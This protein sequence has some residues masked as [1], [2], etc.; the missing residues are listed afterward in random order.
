M[1]IK[2]QGSTIIDDS[3]NIIN[4]TQVGIATTTTSQPFQV[5]SGTT[6]IV[7]D[8]LGDLGIGTPNPTSKLTVVGD[9]LVSGVVTASS[10]RGDGSQLFGVSGGV[11]ISTNTTNQNQFLTYAISTGT[12]TGLGVTTSGLV[13]NPSTTRFGI[14]ITNPQYTFTVTDTGTPATTG[15][16]NCLADFTT[17]AN[18]YGQINLRNTS[19]GTNASSDVIIT[20][21]NGTDSSNFID[22]GI[23]NSGFSVGSWTI[24]GA[25]DGYLYTS[26]GNLSIG[27]INASVAKYISFFTG[28]TLLSNERMRINSTG[29]G[30]NTTNP[31]AT[32]NV[33]PTATSIAGL[34]SGTTSSDMVRITQL[35]TGNALVVEDETNPDAGPFVVK[36]DGSVG[37][38]TTN[39]SDKLHVLGGNIRV[40]SV[41][42]AV[43]FWDGAGFYGGIGGAGGLGGSG[44]DI[45]IRADSTRSIIFFTGGANDR[46]RIDSSGTFLV[47]AATSTGTA[48]QRL[49]VDG[50]AYISG[51]LGIGT[52]NPQGTLQ[53]GAA[54]TMYGSAGIVSATKYYG[55][56]S[57]LTNIPSADSYLFNTGITSSFS[58][59]LLGIGSTIFTFPATAGKKYV[60][61]SVNCSNVSTGNTE[62]NVIGAFDFN[63]GERSYFAYNIPI[64][65]GTA[66]EI[67]KQPQVLN[68]SD[69]IVMRSTN[70]SRV[71]TD[72]IVEVYVSYQEKTTTSYFGIGISTTGFATTDVTGIYTATT[73]PSVIQ[74]IRLANVTDSGGYPV[75]VQITNGLTTTRLV[76]NLIVPKYAS[77]EILDAPKRIE[78]NSV[79]QLQLDQ[80]YTISAQVSGSQITS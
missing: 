40:D 44:T 7:V 19:T 73:Y 18:S 24:N 64:P 21:D 5:G 47:G 31:G 26:D 69:R 1:A 72:S 4:A 55:D 36:G 2:V 61:L 74:S 58:T 12:T 30:I 33:V 77:V 68:P 37:I 43:N 66:V 67:M 14:G 39:T 3:R 48:S 29:V 27:A 22:L 6:I 35:G 79:I 62:V 20:A 46:G 8:N 41:T 38:G 78:T 9:V 54:I 53:V 60:I 32:L 10:F 80:A 65:T 59:A 11:S 52:T 23:N 70:F 49:Q 42:G 71:G 56:G 25:N 13:F 28:G 75:S 17:T 50:G 45:V 63:G 76:D 57:G 34:F 15:L 16:T 51:N